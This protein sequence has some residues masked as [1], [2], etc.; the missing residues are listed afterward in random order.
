MRLLVTTTGPDETQAIAALLAPAL[1]SGDVL[2][3]E[4]DLGAGKT[5][6]VRG[7]ATAM[8]ID[9]NRV[10]SP[11]FIIVQEYESDLDRPLLHVD[12]YRVGDESELDAIG[13]DEMLER[14]EALIVIEWPERISSR[15]PREM[16]IIR[17]VHAGPHQRD[18]EMIIPDSWRDRFT[19]VADQWPGRIVEP[20]DSSHMRASTGADSTCPVC[21]EPLRSN[22]HHPFCSERCRLVDL[23]RWFRG[24]YSVSRPLRDDDEL[25]P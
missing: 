10:S 8:G 17:L 25:E 18:I 1:V 9:P 22:E 21:E 7:L 6:F 14:R 16:I 4:G 11:T 3:L 13:W 12:S 15:L 23:G 2:A 20:K 5:T 24:Q 19:I